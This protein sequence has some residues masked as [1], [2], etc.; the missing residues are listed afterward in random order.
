MYVS[1]NYY[2]TVMTFFKD[3]DVGDVLEIKL[4][5]DDSGVNWDYEGRQIQPSR[6]TILADAQILYPLSLS[7]IELHPQFTKGNPRATAE[8]YYRIEHANNVYASP[9]SAV[10]LY[11]WKITSTYGAFRIKD[12][13]VTYSNDAAKRTSS[14][15]R[16]YYYQNRV[17]TKIMVRGLNV[18]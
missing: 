9:A 11:G 8:S 5:A 4:W 6:V 18:P 1:N 15:Y 12:G 13:D 2:W 14:T 3:V 17:P 16:P 10:S 7:E